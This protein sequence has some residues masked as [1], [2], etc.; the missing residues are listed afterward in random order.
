MLERLV[1]WIVG[2]RRVHGLDLWKICFIVRSDSFLQ[3]VGT[4]CTDL[5]L[6]QKLNK[7]VLI[8]EYASQKVL[9]IDKAGLINFCCP[10]LKA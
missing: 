3:S 5:L 7:L 10:N 2:G 6:L 1:E 4:A 8:F 9:E